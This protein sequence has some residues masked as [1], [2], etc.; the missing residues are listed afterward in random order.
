METVDT[1]KARLNPKKVVV[2]EQEF[3]VAEGDQLLDDDQ[4]ALYADQLNLKQQQKE[5]ANSAANLGESPVGGGLSLLIGV[6]TSDGKLVRW[7]DG[8]TL[9]YCVLRNTFGNNQ[10]YLLARRSMEQATQAWEESCGIK[11]QHVVAKD[12]SPT[13]TVA[14][15]VFTVRKIDAMGRF[16]AAAFFP[17]DPPARRRVLIDPSFFSDS[18]RFDRVGV[19]RHEL[20]HVL[21]FRHEH[22]S[23]SAPAQCPDE[24]IADTSILTGYDPHSVMH[25]FCGG[26][27]SLELLI[28]T[29]DKEGAQKVYGLP[30]SSYT[31]VE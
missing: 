26:V 9:T 13:T 27:G 10:E 21:G 28:T 15:V 30:F 2:D 24:D 12:E 7:K 23:G 19:L 1:L 22:I 31:F 20:G 11:F 4:L 29:V 14:D 3:W 6:T 5:L 18:L 8:L 25:Y 16:I 17:N